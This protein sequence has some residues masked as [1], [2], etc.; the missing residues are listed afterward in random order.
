[1]LVPGVDYLTMNCWSGFAK[2][3]D[4]MEDQSVY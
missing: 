1:M 3:T 4:R 2:G